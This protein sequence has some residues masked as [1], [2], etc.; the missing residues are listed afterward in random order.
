MLAEVVY[1]LESFYRVERVRVAELARSILVF[2]AIR[3]EDED[4]LLRAVEVYE[5]ARL[6]FADAY[7]AASAE[8]F[9]IRN[10]ASFDRSLDRVPTI[11]RI[12]P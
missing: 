5:V 4:L 2:E 3:V 9:G 8:R 10:V 11:S 1:V 7:L 12:G 6:D